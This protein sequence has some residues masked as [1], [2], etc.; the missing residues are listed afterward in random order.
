MSPSHMNTRIV[1][2]YIKK[3]Q[4]IHDFYIDILIHT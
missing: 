2:T 1:S 4:K 3:I